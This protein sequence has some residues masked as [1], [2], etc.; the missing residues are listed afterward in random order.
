VLIAL[1][2]S[3]FLGFWA[4]SALT[5]LALH[6]LG[7]ATTRVLGPIRKGQWGT[8]AWLAI[9]HGS[10]DAQKAIGLVAAVGWASDRARVARPKSSWHGPRW[11]DCTC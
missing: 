7:R 9:S 2:V 4:A 5:R 8:S 1:A 3:P 10:N 6:P 11:Q